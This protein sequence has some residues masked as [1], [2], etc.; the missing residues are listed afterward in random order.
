MITAVIVFMDVV[1]ASSKTLR[2]G[3]FETV[4]LF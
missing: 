4:E 3:R 2:R 1:P